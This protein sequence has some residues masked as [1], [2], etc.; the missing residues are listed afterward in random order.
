MNDNTETINTVVPEPQRRVMRCKEVLEI[1]GYSRST[2]F[3]R[4][5]AGEFPA[6]VRLSQY[7]NAIGWDSLEVQKWVDSRFDPPEE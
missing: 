5:D 4:I 6:P 2:I 3:R 1:T 7:G